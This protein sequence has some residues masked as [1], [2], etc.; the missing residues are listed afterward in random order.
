MLRSH[1]QKLLEIPDVIKK[2]IVRETNKLV[3]IME[4]CSDKVYEGTDPIEDSISL[5]RKAAQKK[6][7]FEKQLMS[8]V[9][10]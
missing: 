1:E 10:E 5:Y 6:I 7:K 4:E 8:S 9:S 3:E 2:M